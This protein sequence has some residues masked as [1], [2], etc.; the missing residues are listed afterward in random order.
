MYLYRIL[1]HP[2]GVPIGLLC[3]P[4]YLYRS[5]MCLYGVHIGL[6]YVPVCTYGVFF[7]VLIGS[8]CAP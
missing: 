2:Y 8:L 4:V 7:G 3:V 6:L 1:M 5:L